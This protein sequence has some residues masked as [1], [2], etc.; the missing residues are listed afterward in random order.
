MK[1][2]FLLLIIAVSISLSTSSQTYITNVTVIDVIKQKLIPDQTVMI[3]DDI[4]TSIQPSKKIKIPAD[5][6]IID[7]TGKFLMPGLTDAHVHFFQSGGLYTRPDAINL[8]KDKPYEKEIEWVHNNMEDFLRRYL[9]CGITSVIDVGDNYSFLRQR[10][11][12]ENKNYAPSIYMTGPCSHL[13]S[14]MFSE[15]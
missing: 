6:A 10:D 7:G 12:F 11:S 8:T 9:K 2:K 5:A 1:G 14:R 4:I 15:I 3:K 13:T